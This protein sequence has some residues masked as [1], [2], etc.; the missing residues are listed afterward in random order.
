MI[1]RE[2]GFDN[3]LPNGW[4]GGNGPSYSPFGLIEGSEAYSH[5]IVKDITR[6]SGSAWRQE[7]RPGDDAVFHGSRRSEITITTKGDTNTYKQTALRFSTYIPSGVWA[8]SAQE[9]IFP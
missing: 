3:P 7:L 6:R 1:Q 8:S 2:S 4:I 9:E 5:A